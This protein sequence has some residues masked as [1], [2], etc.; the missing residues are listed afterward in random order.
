M[1]KQSVLSLIIAAVLLLCAAAAAESGT[2]DV[3]TLYKTRD[4][5]DSWSGV[6]VETIDLSTVTDAEVVIST[7]GNYVLSGKYSGRILINAP[8]EDKV[9]LILNGAEI[10]SPEGPAIYEKQADKLIITI[11]ADTE[12]TLTDGTPVTDDDDT[13]GAVLYAE[14]DLSIN[15]TGSLTVNGTQKHGIQSKADLILAN[16][17]ITVTAVKDGVRG[18]NSILILDGELNITAD[19]DGITST[20]KDSDGK[21]WIVLAGGQVTV[22]TGNGAAGASKVKSSSRKGIKAAAD[23][24]ALGGEYTLDCEDDG[25]NA[26]SITLYGG[27]FDIRSGDDCMHADGK[28][29]ITGG[30]H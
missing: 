17:K 13:I 1:K 20:R 19:G 16:G 10:T 28:L 7:K 11:A 26:A 9:R 6:E 21:G 22:K 4:T 25:I 29:T 15:G 5:D 18:R 3:T 12:N 24:T 27:N 8:E 30:K 14:D 23:L 2:L